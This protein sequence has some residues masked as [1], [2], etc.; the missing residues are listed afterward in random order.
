MTNQYGRR[1]SDKEDH[2]T[3]VVLSTEMKQLCRLV[4]EVRDK[5]DTQQE[6]CSNKASDCNKFF[7]PNKVFYTALTI[8]VLVIGSV[9]TVAINTEKEITRH[10][11][12]AKH[13]KIEMDKRL[14]QLTDKSHIHNY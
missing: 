11:S 3:L 14:D 10:I 2:D 4:R 9:G 12:A 7:V 8:I 13:V 5:Q 6:I 1:A